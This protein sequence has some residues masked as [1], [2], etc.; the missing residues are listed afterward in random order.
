M[1]NEII[2]VGA[3]VKY[4]FETTAGTRQHFLCVHIE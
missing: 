3:R 2:T 4:A 1:A